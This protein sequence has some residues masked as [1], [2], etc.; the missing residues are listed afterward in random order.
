MASE[1]G[2]VRF[3]RLW[4]TGLGFLAASAVAA[5]ES[6]PEILPTIPLA[7][8]APS[9]PAPAAAAPRGAVIEEVIV[10]ATKRAVDAR[11]LPISVDA[12]TGEQ[13]QKAGAD[14]LEAITRFSP[15]VT[16]S[17]GLDAE[18]ASVIFR[19]VSTDT[20][21]TFFTRTFGLFYEDVSLVNPSI[22]GPQP[23]L[24]PFDMAT[25][26][27][28]KGPQ[29]TLFGGSA[30]SGAVR[31]VPAKPEYGEAYG[32]FSSGIGTMAK[33]DDL[34][35]YYAGM[36]NQ[37][38]TDGLAV[39]VV[40]SRRENPGYVYDQRADRDDINSSESTQVRALLGWRFGADSDLQLN[41][42][43]RLSTQD[44]GSFASRDDAAVHEHRFY[45]DTLDSRTT[46]LYAKLRVGFDGFDTF[47]IGSQLNKTYNQ[48]LDYSQF[49][50]TSALGIGALGGTPSNSTQP[51][52]EL[53][54]VSTAPTESGFWLLDRW[55]Y[56]AGYYY[57][58][59]D[60]FLRLN[61][62]PQF[63]GLTLRLQGDVDAKENALFFDTTR[64]IGER[65]QLGL[66]GRLFRQTTQAAISTKVLPLSAP[67][68]PN[69]P[70]LPEG[71][72]IPLGTNRGTIGETVFNPKF[73]LQWRY[74][75]DF[76][77]YGSAVK[78]FRY[79]GAN[80]NPTL[81][82]QVPLF[83]DSD[84][85]WNYELGTRTTWFDGRLQWDT[86]AFYLEW[87]DMQIQQRDYTGVF[88]Y[89]DNVGGARTIGI[90]TS[91]KA[92]FESGFL[93]DLNLGYLDAQTTEFFDD[94]QGPAPKGTELPGSSPFTGS[95]LVN[96]ARQI[97]NSEL[98]ATLSYTYQN[99][100]YNNL[101]HTYEH[102]ALGLLGARIGVRFPGW[103]GAPDLSLVGSNLTNEFKPAVVFDTPNTG[104]ILAI[105]NQPR[106]L[107]LKLGFEVGR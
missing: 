32:R 47:L 88:A 44:D 97:S 25:V 94:F 87:S 56:V 65:W 40:A 85:I 14:S 4:L 73:T 54:I 51:S 30:L 42:M 52:A 81:D 48:N 90:E 72:A 76:S 35:Q 3:G 100:N 16:V 93:V 102:P 37:P 64:E 7:E 17:P 60:Q 59:T 20:F 91:F 74:S 92:A 39:R 10:T 5:Q 71:V 66:G 95:L 6:S 11:E 86:T 26:E 46:A 98:S 1:S 53:R 63:T 104:G 96:Y 36:W 18:S 29:G 80:Q 15:G 107:I 75:R 84:S 105:Y 23:N 13:L 79:A 78:G 28:L 50:G 70:T 31:Y 58:Y 21:F 99:R 19:G 77:I 8:D 49:L 68:L 82:P 43:Q 12:F 106:T 22:L 55:S 9:V 33:S 2:S 103:P 101:P 67:I 57:V 38:I 83:F 61:L 89:T 24:D 34:S 27:V 41:W 62:V 45:P 69:L